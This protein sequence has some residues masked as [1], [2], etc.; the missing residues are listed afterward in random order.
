[1]RLMRSSSS[2]CRSWP[3]FSHPCSPFVYGPRARG[4][5]VGACQRAHGPCSGPPVPQQPLPK[6]ALCQQ[7]LAGFWLLLRFLCG[8]LLPLTS[9]CKSSL[10][11]KNSLLDSGRF[12]HNL[13]GFLLGS[14][15]VLAGFCRGP[16]GLFVRFLAGL[17]L[18]SCSAIAWL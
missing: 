6:S 5:W 10:L 4:T 16:C 13:A 9:L 3:R 18:G 15:W 1:M 7:A 2:L 17:F 8:I 14:C 11:S 12:L